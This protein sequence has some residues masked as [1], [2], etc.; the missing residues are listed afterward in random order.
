MKSLK[1]KLFD[2]ADSL[3]WSVNIYA[4]TEWEFEK[5]SPAGEDFIF[6]I[7]AD[8]P[9]DV[10]REVRRYANDFDQDEHIEM[11]VNARHNVSGVPNIRVLVEDAA[12]IEKMLDELA[13]A[14]KEVSEEVV[15][16]YQK[17]KAT[18]AKWITFSLKG[19]EIAAI[20]INGTFFGEVE[21]TV[22][23]LAHEKEVDPREIVV[24]IR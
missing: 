11:W 6:T 17:K 24:G 9:E 16:D 7:T 20:S 1:R 2:K 22:K 4:K 21:D 19:K 15:L 3:N 23:L 8:K 5:Y 18:E 10:W 12:E 13:D 14:L